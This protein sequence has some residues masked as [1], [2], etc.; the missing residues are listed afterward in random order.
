MCGLDLIAIAPDYRRFRVNGV[1]PNSPAAEA[2]LEINDEI[3]AI[4]LI[5]VTAWSLTQINQLF[6]SR[7]GREIN[8]LCKRNGVLLSFNVKLK[9]RI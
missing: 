3:I 9:R 1:H 6:H 2:G 8:F 4:D 7:S 5:Q